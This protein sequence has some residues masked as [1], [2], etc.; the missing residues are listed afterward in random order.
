MAYP[1]TVVFYPDFGEQKSRGVGRHDRMSKP[2]SYLT[3]F[4]VKPD[5]KVVIPDAG[6]L[7]VAVVRKVYGL[8]RDAINKASTLVIC[9]VDTDDYK[10]RKARVDK[11]KELKTRLETI[12]LDFESQEI[13]RLMAESNPRAKALMDELNKLEG[14]FIEAPKGESK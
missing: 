8:S 10:E 7:R 6:N 1:I 9:L 5:D 13:Y 2:Y 4:E 11:A 12:E 3:D 14:N